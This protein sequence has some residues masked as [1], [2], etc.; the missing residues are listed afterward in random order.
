A[1]PDQAHTIRIPPYLTEVISAFNSCERR[2][3]QQLGR[4]PTEQEMAAEMQ[5]TVERV[6]EIS[7]IFQRPLS[8]EARVGDDDSSVGDFVEDRQSVD[9][10]DAASLAL[11]RSCLSEALNSLPVRERQVLALRFGLLD[12]RERSLTEIGRRFS[13]TRE[14]IRQLELQALRKIQESGHSGALRNYLA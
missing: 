14:R 4:D 8:L 7:H 2:L 5:M 6:R 12:G 3:T 9:P 13:V 10:A 11:L 1:L